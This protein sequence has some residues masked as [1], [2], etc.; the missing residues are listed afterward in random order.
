MV[1]D[2]DRFGWYGYGNTAADWY[3]DMSIV[4]RCRPH[5]AMTPEEIH[6]WMEE[7]R[8]D[9]VQGVRE[10]ASDGDGTVRGVPESDPVGLSGSPDGDTGA[11]PVGVS[12]RLRGESEAPAGE[13]RKG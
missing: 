6:A 3:E 8:D 11:V 1:R 4:S 10:Q 5:D 12:D 13:D 9:D 2:Y 7:H